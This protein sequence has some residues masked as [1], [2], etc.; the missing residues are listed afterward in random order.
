MALSIRAIGVLAV[1]TLLLAPPP[2]FAQDVGALPIPI[3]EVSGGYVFMRDTDIDENFPGGWYFSGA[4]N[5]TRWFGIVGEV[6]GSYKK[7]DETFENLTFANRLQLY[8]FMGGPRF[9][10]Q[11]GRVVPFAQVLAGVAHGRVKVTLP[12]E[13]RGP[14]LMKSSATDFAIQPG[15]GVTVYLSDRVGLRL[16]ADYRSIFDDEWQ[17]TNEFRALAGFTFGWGAR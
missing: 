3:A 5:A 16:A 2:A 12:P 8:T 13:L 15:G 17:S 6:S 7:L 11:M 1:G 10:G 14:A 4:V 9:F